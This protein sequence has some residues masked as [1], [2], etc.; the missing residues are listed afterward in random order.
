MK[1]KEGVKSGGTDSYCELCNGEAV[2]R[3]VPCGI[4]CCVQHLKPHQQKG[5]K[6]VG[7]GVK[8]EELR[9]IDHEK[10]IQLYCKDDGSLMCVM[11]TGEQHQNHNIVAVE[12]AHT[13]LK[14]SKS[15][16]NGYCF[17]C[18]HF[19]LNMEESCV[20]A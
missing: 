1:V 19:F 3:C 9:C 12:I 11:C 17:Y 4:L 8:I 7:P 15:V 20:W 2:K 18:I 6:L 16:K 14:V 5:H 10:P 13:E